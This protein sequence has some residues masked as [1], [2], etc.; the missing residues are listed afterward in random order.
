MLASAE[1]LGCTLCATPM[2]YSLHK[3]AK[4]PEIGLQGWAL[5]LGFFIKK[6]QHSTEGPCAVSCLCF[7]MNTSLLRA[8][9]NR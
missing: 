6:C 1:L 8:R 9:G 4:L 7:V 3:D 2:I 5:H